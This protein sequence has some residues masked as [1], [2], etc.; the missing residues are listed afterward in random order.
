MAINMLNKGLNT[1][2]LKIIALVFMVFDHIGYM[3]GEQLGIP[4]WFRIIGRISAP[5]FIFII[6]NGMAH[7]SNP[8]KYIL[9]LYLFSCFMMVGNDLA[10]TYFPHPKGL[11]VIN[12]IF[13]TLIM[14]ALYI[15]IIDGIIGAIKGRKA[16]QALGYFF[17]GSLP[18]ITSYI[19]IFLM[20][21]GDIILY[22][23]YFNLVP[24]LIFIEGGIL[25]VL[26]G[27]GFYYCR[28]SKLI[29]SL[30]YVLYSG[31]FFYGAAAIEISYENLLVRNYQWLMILALPLILL[32]NNEKGPSRKWFFYIFYP[33]H[34]Y[35]FLILSL[36]IG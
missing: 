36:L 35:A 4:Y 21:R 17:L 31:I 9:R 12:N 6:A 30:F 20:T 22:R 14:I 26:L 3:F 13:S 32:Y 5:I 24:T 7:T 28:R 23:L 27:I 1:Y 10:N 2:Q 8:K 29:T 16:Y 33:A 15:V 25:F 18:A 11:M 19:G 34:I